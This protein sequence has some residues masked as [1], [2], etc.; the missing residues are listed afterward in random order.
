MWSQ[1]FHCSLFTYGQTGSGKTYTITGPQDDPGIVPRL[2]TD[3]FERLENKQ[4]AGEQR[5]ITLAALASLVPAF[6]RKIVTNHSRRTRFTE[7]GHMLS[8][9]MCL[10][11]SDTKVGNCVNRW[12]RQFQVGGTSVDA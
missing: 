6:G 4:L 10:I 8:S 9:M 1:G 2:V 12:K 7:H 11:L 3:L 5:E